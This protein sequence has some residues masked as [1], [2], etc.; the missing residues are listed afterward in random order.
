MNN[1]LTFLTTKSIQNYKYLYQI[2]LH[3]NMCILNINHSLTKRIG[4]IVLST[5]TLFK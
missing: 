1:L 2:N 5:H 3:R 4:K